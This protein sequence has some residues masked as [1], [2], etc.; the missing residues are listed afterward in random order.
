VGKSTVSVKV[1]FSRPMTGAEIISII[2][3]A[4]D[5]KSGNRSKPTFLKQQRDK[6][7]QAFSIGQTSTKPHEHLLVIPLGRGFFSYVDY[8]RLNER[9]PGIELLG[10]PQAAD[11]IEAFAEKLRESSMVRR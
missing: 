8:F 3:D 2:E 9:Y 7:E 1:E 11:A 5:N 6:Y 4:V 10:Q